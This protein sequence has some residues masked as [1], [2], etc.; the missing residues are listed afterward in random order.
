MT[1]RPGSR[2]FVKLG[3]SFSPP[4]WR[5]A[6][7]I[8][9][10][11]DWLQCLVR[12][13]RPEADA[14]KLSSVETDEGIFCLVETPFSRLLSGVAGDYRKLDANAKDL[15]EAA[16]KSVMSE[17]DPVYATASDPED[18]KKQTHRKR[19]EKK[20]A[21]SSSSE[22][23]EEAEVNLVDMLRKKWLPS[24]TARGS[25]E[26]QEEVK[27]PRDQSRSR[28]FALLD[29]RD[30][31][32][33]GTSN[34]EELSEELM[35]KAASPGGDPLQSLLALQLVQSM[36]DRQKRSSRRKSPR[37][38][39]RSGSSS[40]SAAEGADR[41]LKG[42]SKAVRDYQTSG[43]RMKRNPIKYVRRYVRQLEDELGARDRPFRVVDHNKRIF[44]GKHRSLQRT[45]YLV[46][47]IL[48]LLL[49]ERYDLAALQTVLT[50]QSLHQCALDGGNWEVAWLLTHCENPFEKRVFGGDPQNLQ[51]VTSYL[52]SMNELMKTTQNLRSKGAGR[53][54][55][56][57]A[58]T[59]QEGKGKRR[60]KNKEKD[61][62]QTE[63]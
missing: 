15:L 11:G 54:E 35:I 38:Q 5:E 61:K 51:S 49:K 40:E 53:G 21:S 43:K 34:I 47:I 14:T 57:D 26:R 27:S 6:L 23:S 28:R 55:A 9:S 25:G 33:K 16:Q 8:D 19:R 41:A 7:V 22:E 42:H 62:P 10:Q 37:S 12:C 59:Q 50:L 24:G 32:G 30:K 52:K 63:S 3:D 45:H 60:G 17:S 2:G 20:E 18:P 31:K 46:G 48:E 4:H 36:Q 1:L 44:W 13:S 58:E 29:K 56:E 39:S